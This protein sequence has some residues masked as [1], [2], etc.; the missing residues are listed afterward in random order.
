MNFYNLKDE[1]ELTLTGKQLREWKE[2]IIKDF[3]DFKEFPDS[4]ISGRMIVNPYWLEHLLNLFFQ[5]Y[6]GEVWEEV[7]DTLINHRIAIENIVYGIIGREF[8][9]KPLFAQNN[10]FMTKPKGI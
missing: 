2:I 4:N 10:N 3:L 6:L 1:D 5:G 8:N 7:M 9:K